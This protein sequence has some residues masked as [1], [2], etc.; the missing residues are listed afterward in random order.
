MDVVVAALDT[1]HDGIVS[2]ADQNVS[3]NV[4]GYSWGGFNA[5]DFINAVNGDRRFAPERKTISRY[6]ALDAFRTD[7]LVIPRQWLDVPANV[8]RFWS[9]RHSVAPAND[10]SIILD[11]LLG[12]FTGRTPYCTGSTECHD[13]DFSKADATKGVDHCEVP[14]VANPFV[15][16]LTLNQPVSGLPPE[17]RV[18]RY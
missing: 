17:L 5:L 18:A 7:F 1:N 14:E 2:G 4:V 6:F 3:L 10:C 11:G 16:G 13:Y 8:K 12:P 9:F 15:V